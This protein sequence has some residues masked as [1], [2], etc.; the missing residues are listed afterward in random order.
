MKYKLNLLLDDGYCG[1]EVRNEK[2]N[3]SKHLKV[4]R[5]PSIVSDEYTDKKYTRGKIL[6]KLGKWQRRKHHGMN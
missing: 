6:N 2:E 3:I 1:V 5:K 4:H